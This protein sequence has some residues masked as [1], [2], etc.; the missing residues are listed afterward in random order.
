MAL[1]LGPIG[2]F[3][4]EEALQEESKS[5]VEHLRATRAGLWQLYST[6][7]ENGDVHGASTIALRLIDCNRVIGKIT[8]ELLDE[9]IRPTKVSFFASPEFVTFQAAIMR[10]LNE[11]PS[12]RVAVIKEL[13]QLETNKESEN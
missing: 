5:V 2:K 10:V 8:G 4:L 9:Y 1:S 12:A 7:I 11:Y 6:C 3:T 13:K